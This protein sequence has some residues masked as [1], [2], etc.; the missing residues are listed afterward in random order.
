M[1]TK[2]QDV[3]PDQ[4]QFQIPSNSSNFAGYLS[5]FLKH[6]TFCVSNLQAT[7]LFEG[8]GEGTEAAEEEE[9][10]LRCTFVPGP[11]GTGRR[12]LLG[13]LVPP[14]LPAATAAAA[15]LL[16]GTW[17]SRCASTPLHCT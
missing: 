9:R 3:S 13:R 12:K 6:E 8:E 11:G 10:V 2:K 14:A 5:T 1:K 16:N 15:R 17:V 4:T 7:W